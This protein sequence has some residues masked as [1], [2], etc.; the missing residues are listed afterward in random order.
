MIL[1]VTGGIS[2]G[3]S[4]AADVIAKSGVR[5]IDCDEVSRY[6]TSYDPTILIAIFEHFGS[7]VFHR[8]GQLK[9]DEM[10]RIVMN[11]E[12]ERRVLERIMHPPIKAVVLANIE[13]ALDHD[14]PLVIAAP[15]L[16]EAGMAGLVDRLWVIS[17]SPENQLARLCQRSGIAPEDARAWIEAQMSLQ[18]KEKYADTVI[19]NDGAIDDFRA[20]VAQEWDALVA[21][22]PA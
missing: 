5:I 3:K 10:A 12:V 14:E 11:D 18:E 22:L 6:L 4:T 19:R 2:T 8:F 20:A 17:C 7:R 16:I 9:R 15:L 21:E 13:T 1:G